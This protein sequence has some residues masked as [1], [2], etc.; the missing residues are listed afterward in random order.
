MDPL[1]GS[2]W[3]AE[4]SRS[5]RPSRQGDWRARRSLHWWVGTVGMA[6]WYG[7]PLLTYL[8]IALLAWLVGPEPRGMR[9]L[10]ALQ[11]IIWPVHAASWLVTVLFLG[12]EHRW[13]GVLL[14]VLSAPVVAFS[15]FYIGAMASCIYFRNCM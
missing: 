15:I 11:H 7:A 14:V 1:A 6:L 13:V 9:Q 3:E 8:A 10:Y 5:W 2:A 12:L 4:E